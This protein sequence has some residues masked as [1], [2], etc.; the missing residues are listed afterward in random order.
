MA[1][2]EQRERLRDELRKAFSRFSD[3]NNSINLLLTERLSRTNSELNDL[4]YQLFNY[5]DVLE[6]QIIQHESKLNALAKTMPGLKP[7]YA[8]IQIHELG[9]EELSNENTA[10]TI[11]TFDLYTFNTNKLSG[12]IHFLTE[13]SNKDKTSIEIVITTEDD[14]EKSYYTAMPFGYHAE[15]YEAFKRTFKDIETCSTL[16]RT[17]NYA[18]NYPVFKFTET[19]LED[20]VKVINEIKQDCF[21]KEEILDL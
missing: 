2:K 5:V 20:I 18:F 10:F 14:K 9:E 12:H 17:A 1:N 15:L 11:T 13:A 21:N 8:P 7:V 6:K 19:K 16:T 3:S 4:L